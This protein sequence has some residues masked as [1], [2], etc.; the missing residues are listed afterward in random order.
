MEYP[1]DENMRKKL[2]DEHTKK[3]LHE[4]CLDHSFVKRGKAY[5]RVHGDGVLQTIMFQYERVMTHFELKVGLQSMYAEQPK[6]HFTS[7]GCI[8]QYYVFIPLGLD[9]A[10]HMIEIN[11]W[12]DFLVD[13]PEIQVDQLEKQTI[14]ILDSI[15]NQQKLADALWK[16]SPSWVDMEKLAPF[17]ATNQLE[18]AEKVVNAFLYQHTPRDFKAFFPKENWSHKDYL[19]YSEMFPQKDHHLLR[20]HTWIYNNDLNAIRAYLDKN[21]LTNCEYAK[22]CMKNR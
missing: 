7:S 8:P 19:R 17:L 21:Y 16:Y 5:F 22:F 11:N 10:V 6:L 13:P 14:K 9:N 15:D 18:K 12:V 1:L 2:L 20:F 3:R 4:I